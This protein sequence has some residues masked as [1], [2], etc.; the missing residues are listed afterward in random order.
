[1]SMPNP[2]AG[3]ARWGTTVLWIVLVLALAGDAFFVG[4]SLRHGFLRHRPPSSTNL[5]IPPGV[6]FAHLSPETMAKV[7]AAMRAHRD[8]FT[9]Q[10]AAVIKARNEVIEAME[11]EPFDLAAYKKA[12]EHS[13]QVEAQGREQ[14]N[15]FFASIITDLTPEE[16]KAIAQSLDIRASKMS[17]RQG[18][19]DR[20]GS[21]WGPN[22]PG[23][24]PGPGGPPPGA[25][26]G[27]PPM[28]S[29]PAGSPPGPAPD[30]Q[31]PSP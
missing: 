28:G 14:A 4:M 2:S 10:V 8:S 9:K 1:M 11:A 21:G 29:P 31:S 13:A 30:G 27:S 3:P 6:Y 24:G 23:P 20:R 7:N 19:R 12:L 17:K 15:A 26:M 18:W 22:G 5:S 16:R 25:P